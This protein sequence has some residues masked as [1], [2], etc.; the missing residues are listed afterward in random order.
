[1]LFVGLSV[2][3]RSEFVAETVVA[4]LDNVK[5]EVNLLVDLLVLSTRGLV[6]GDGLSVSRDGAFSIDFV[7][8]PTAPPLGDDVDESPREDERSALSLETLSRGD[9]FADVTGDGE[10]SERRS[11][12]APRNRRL[13]LDVCEPSNR[14]K[15]GRTDS[16]FPAR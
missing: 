1:M 11:V 9:V 12:D 6:R 2:L 14:E 4:F 8:L 7:L 5:P 10:T 16:A 15:R 3:S 13:N